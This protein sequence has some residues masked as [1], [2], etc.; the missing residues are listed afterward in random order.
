[1]VSKFWTASMAAGITMLPFSGV[2]AQDYP[3]KEPVKIVMPFAPGG[4][5]HGV[6][7]LLAQLLSEEL[8]SEFY[9]ETRPGAGG[10]IGHDYVSKQEPD[11]YT[12]L[13]GVISTTT[14]LP[15]MRSDLPWDPVDDFAPITHFASGSNVLVVPADSPYDT[16]DSLVE[17]GRDANGN[18]TCGSS[19][20]G[21]TLHLSCVL[22]NQVAGTN[23]V[24]VPYTGNAPAVVGLVGGETSMMFATTDVV[25]FVNDGSARALAVSSSEQLPFLPDVPTVS[26]LGYPELTIDSWY[27]LFAPEGT[28]EEIIQTLSDAVAAFREKDEWVDGLAQVRMRPAE[29]NGP[30]EFEAFVESELERWAPIVEASGATAQ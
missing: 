24:H 11:G 23:F 27:G 15:A 21:T 25:E 9:V 2:L 30:E 26:E 7:N 19:G 17:A 14:M 6:T 12:L 22:L 13:M 16:I 1:M 5:G 3:S 29:V 28:P 4:V 18:L 20:P 8:A 10:A